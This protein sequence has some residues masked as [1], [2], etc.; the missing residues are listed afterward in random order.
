MFEHW[1]TRERSMQPYRNAG[2]DDDNDGTG[3]MQDLMQRQ[4]QLQMSNQM[5]RSMSGGTVNDSSGHDPRVKR[6][7]GAGCIVL[8][9]QAGGTLL[10]S[11]N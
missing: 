6:S 5:M 7:V 3:T 10:S 9:A 8:C 1:A 11:A 4:Q 2:I